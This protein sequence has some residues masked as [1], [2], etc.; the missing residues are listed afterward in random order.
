MIAFLP[1]ILLSGLMLLMVVMLVLWLFAIWK[2]SQ[3]SLLLK[4]ALTL[5]IVVL[6]LATLYV[7][8]GI[9]LFAVN[10]P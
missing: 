10:T 1:R 9:L 8:L 6:M 7:I 2:K 5:L 3:F 4:C